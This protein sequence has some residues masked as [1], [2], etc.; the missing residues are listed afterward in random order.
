MFTSTVR[1]STMVSPGE[2]QGQ[3]FELQFGEGHLLAVDR[4]HLFVHVEADALV[5]DFVLRGFGLVW[6][7]PRLVAGV[8]AAVEHRLHP[9]L[10]LAHAE[11][12]ADIVIGADGEALQ[13][14][15]LHGLGGAEDDGNSGGRGVGLE[16]LRPFE[17]RFWSH[18]HIEQDE[19]GQGGR[20]GDGRLGGGHLVALH[21]E[22]EAEYLADVRFVVN[23]KN[24]WFCHISYFVS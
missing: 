14:V 12:F 2:Q 24:S 8:Q 5:D 1:S 20:E 21:L 17:A 11:G 22:V 19:L 7:L 4:T 18:H 3:Q 13:Q 15:L 23:D 9:C 16:F 6:L 10:H